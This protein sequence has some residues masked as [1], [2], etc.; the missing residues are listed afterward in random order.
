MAQDGNPRQASP[1]ASLPSEHSRS[2]APPPT[3]A[4]GE[5]QSP[6]PL[7]T[8]EPSVAA[9]GATL[10]MVNRV[11][12]FSGG[13][14]GSSSSQAQGMKTFSS[15]HVDNLVQLKEW[16]QLHAYLM[17]FIPGEEPFKSHPMLFLR[18]F[19]CHA[20]DLIDQNK[21]SDAEML[22][23]AEMQPF[24]KLI[25]QGQEGLRNAT[26]AELSESLK[27]IKGCLTA[28]K[29]LTH[30]YTSIL[31]TKIA[32]N[33]YMRL[34][35][36]NA[37]GYKIVRKKD[38]LWVF[39]FPL[40][41]R[42]A[43]KPTFRCLGCSLKI[44]N[45]GTIQDISPH[46]DQCPGMSTPYLIEL[47]KL[48]RT[49][50]LINAEN[51]PHKLTQSEQPAEKRRRTLTDTF[52]PVDKRDVFAEIQREVKGAEHLYNQ[53]G[54][55]VNETV[56][57]FNTMGTKVG[58]IHLLHDKMGHVI[59]KM[60]ELVCAGPSVAEDEEGANADNNVEVEEAEAAEDEEG[61][62]ATN[63]VEVE[64]AEAANDAPFQSDAIYHY[65]EFASLGEM[66]KSAIDPTDELMSTEEMSG[67]F[68]GGYF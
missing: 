13:T 23:E 4:Q 5:E 26:I 28:K 10:G 31:M 34:Y 27:Y 68:A 51:S 21:I 39:A 40:A 58:N 14:S 64:E 55:E 22:F 49:I 67:S 36:P 54:V 8:E 16:D 24:Q 62:A 52:I 65:G 18:I 20:V 50:N 48:S 33:D 7:V 53:I 11:T 3:V 44:F 47:L 59:N 9:A 30:P 60:K 32:V 37:I 66:L 25:D 63:N 19:M 2:T 1:S 6:P 35:L 17:E 61:A 42:S 15:A 29:S 56:D 38:A 12:R 43:T 41:S 46:L 57:M 45:S